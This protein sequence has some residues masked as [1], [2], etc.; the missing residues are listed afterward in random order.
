MSQLRAWSLTLSDTPLVPV[1]SEHRGC[2]LGHKDHNRGLDLN[3]L[4]VV[5]VNHLLQTLHS[6]VI[7]VPGITY[8]VRTEFP[9]R[10][11]LCGILGEAGGGWNSLP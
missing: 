5:A 2:Q 8:R 7:M 10:T 9:E 4:G 1:P 6:S 3:V 11:I